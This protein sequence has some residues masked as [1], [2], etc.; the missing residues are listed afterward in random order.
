MGDCRGC[1]FLELREP[2]RKDDC[3]TVHC[4]DPDKPLMGACRTLA[5]GW[6]GF[7]VNIPR[8]AWCR[9]KEKI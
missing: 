1:R 6:A 4:T 8:P 2:L 7:P 9:G 5:V 3:Y